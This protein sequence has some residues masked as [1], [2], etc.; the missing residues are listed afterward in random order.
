MW[1][2][3]A[4]EIMIKQNHINLIKPYLE[5]IK[6]GTAHLLTRIAPHMT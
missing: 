5:L 2:S 3:E 4:F 1:Y 6:L